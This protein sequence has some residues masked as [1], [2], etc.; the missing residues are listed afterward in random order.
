MLA[1]EHREERE[2]VV[3]DWLAAAATFLFNADATSLC[4]RL[5]QRRF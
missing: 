2:P 5:A 1:C 3:L 4:V